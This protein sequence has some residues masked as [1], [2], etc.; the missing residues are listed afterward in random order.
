MRK[1]QA[2]D[3]GKL[4]SRAGFERVFSG[5]KQHIAHVD[6]EAA[7]RT[8]RFEDHGELLAE[9][10]FESR[11][12]LFRL[13]SHPIGFRGGQARLLRFGQG[14]LPLRFGGGSRRFESGLFR[15]GAGGSPVGLPLGL[16]R[17]LAA[18]CLRLTL[19]RR[20]FGVRSGLPFRVRVAGSHISRPL[21]RSFP[22][23]RGEPR[24]PSPRRHSAW[25]PRNKARR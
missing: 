23:Y 5:V 15:H 12:V 19:R 14:P 20:W 22:P 25:S 6:D 3:F 2:R 24:S 16:L 21:L 11:F 10:L 8:A 17:R 9:L 18:S 7:R 4:L 1:Y 13:A